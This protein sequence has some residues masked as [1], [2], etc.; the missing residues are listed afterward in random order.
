MAV[1]GKRE[2]WV[3]YPSFNTILCLPLLRTRNIRADSN[4]RTRENSES[5]APNNIPN[6]STADEIGARVRLE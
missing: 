3:P 2:D 6:S 4:P 5:A 1:L